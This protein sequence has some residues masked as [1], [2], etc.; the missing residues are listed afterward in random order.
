MKPQFIS[1]KKVVLIRR[2]TNKMASSDL[3]GN[4]LDNP[5][6]VLQENNNASNMDVK[7]PFPQ[8]ET[9]HNY[10][11]GE[12]RRMWKNL[13]VICFAFMLLF[14]AFQSMAALQNS[15]NNPVS[16]NKSNVIAVIIRTKINPFLTI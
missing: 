13:V 12:T 14:T 1:R 2:S 7:R 10:G 15:I 6:F 3:E 9:S 16:K 11:P 4:G 5:G 8:T